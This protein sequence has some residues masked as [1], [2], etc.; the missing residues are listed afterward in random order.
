MTDSSFIQ[1]HYG[2]LARFSVLVLGSEVLFWF[3]VPGSPVS[4]NRN[5]NPAPR[6]KNLEPHDHNSVRLNQSTNAAIS[7]GSR[8]SST[9]PCAIVSVR[10]TSRSP[11]TDGRQMADRSRA[12]TDLWCCRR[13]APASRRTSSSPP[14]CAAPCSR[15]PATAARPR[16][17]RDR[18]RRRARARLAPIDAPAMPMLPGITSGRSRRK[19]FAART[20]IAYA[21]SSS[22]LR[23][24]RARTANPASDN[25]DAAASQ[26]A[27][28]RL[29]MG[30]STMPGAGRL[31]RLVDTRRS[32]W[33]RLR[34][35][36]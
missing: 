14:R 2:S 35:G 28:E 3:W 19:A 18:R 20:S 31:R 10:R 30:S 8:E 33:R 12:R 7:S 36:T 1:I 11:G 22:P 17:R 21:A 34:R 26:S 13:A 15:C 23:K 32:T 6:T 5:R 29:S 16:A 25:C 27:C 9:V 4:K 24:S